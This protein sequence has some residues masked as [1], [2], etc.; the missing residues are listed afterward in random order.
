MK[1]LLLSLLACITLL[2][3]EKKETEPPAPPP[4]P[5]L[6]ENFELTCE[7]AEIDR[8]PYNNHHFAT[9]FFVMYNGQAYRIA[10]DNNI[11]DANAHVTVENE[12]LITD[13]SEYREGPVVESYEF[14]NCA[15]TKYNIEFFNG[16]HASIT[17]LANATFTVDETEENIARYKSDVN[18]LRTEARENLKETIHKIVD[19]D[20]L[21]AGNQPQGIEVNIKPIDWM[22][23]K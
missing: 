22:P 10:L 17:L 21:N 4:P 13:S 7:I 18:L 15:R 8:N 23:E 16:N 12:D 11:M 1:K 3:C 5:D 20:I 9:V 2:G 6:G 14:S 19:T